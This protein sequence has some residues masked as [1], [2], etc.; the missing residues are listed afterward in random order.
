MLLARWVGKAEK[1]GY[2]L[3]GGNGDIRLKVC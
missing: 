2:G 1:V 3:G